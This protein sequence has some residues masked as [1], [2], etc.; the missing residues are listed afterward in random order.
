VRFPA[1]IGVLVVLS[2]AQEAK[3]ARQIP[4]SE[5]LVKANFELKTPSHVFGELKDPTGA[6]FQGSKVILKKQGDKGSFTDYRSVTTDKAG[7]FDLKLVDPGKY[8]F[9]PSP[10]RGWKQPA[11][12]GCESSPVC[13]IKLALELNPT[14]QPYAGCPIR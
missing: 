11:D 7:R 2:F 5:E 13:E 4:C 8:R 6:A 9:L 3:E 1:L 10:N 12:V 14:D